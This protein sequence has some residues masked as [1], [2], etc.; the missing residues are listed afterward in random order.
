M[1][2]SDTA[3]KSLSRSHGC[4]G[5]LEQFRDKVKNFVA[6]TSYFT[7]TISFFGAASVIFNKDLE[8]FLKEILHPLGTL[9]AHWEKAESLCYPANPKIDE[10]FQITQGILEW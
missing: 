3:D 10:G 8:I 2:L 5:K 7:G 4:K 1:G 9:Q 6:K